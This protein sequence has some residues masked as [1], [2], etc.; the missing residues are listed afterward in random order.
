MHLH[1]DGALDSSVGRATHWKDLNVDLVMAMLFRRP[2]HRWIVALPLSRRAR[3]PQLR[4]P[5]L[6]HLQARVL[7]IAFLQQPFRD[8][9]GHLLGNFDFWR[10]P[11]RYEV[12]IFAWG[13]Q[14]NIVV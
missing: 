4:L 14:R 9:L 8:V 7:V 10:R 1:V 12:S 6:Q 11:D 2:R 5:Q 13:R 3:K